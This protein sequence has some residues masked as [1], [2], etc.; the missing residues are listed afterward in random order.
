M[1][2]T[3]PH[4]LLQGRSIDSSLWLR[5]SVQRR[6][7]IMKGN[8]MSG[9][10]TLNIVGPDGLR[11]GSRRPQSV[12]IAEWFL[13][14][15]LLAIFAGRGFLP[16]WRTLNTDNGYSLRNGKWNRDLE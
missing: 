6:A 7:S 12:A 8:T 11:S 1:Q 2:L 4:R 13:L 15:A 5:M 9:E 14:V 16:A 3:V 10:A